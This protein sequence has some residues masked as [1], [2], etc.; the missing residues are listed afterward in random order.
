M[1][2]V[3]KFHEGLPPSRRGTTTSIGCGSWA[4]AKTNQVL[5]SE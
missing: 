4:W 5:V 1:F 3:M 2:F